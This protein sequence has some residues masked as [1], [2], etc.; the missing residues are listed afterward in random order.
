MSFRIQDNIPALGS[1]EHP[2]CDAYLDGQWILM[3]YDAKNHLIKHQF[4]DWLSPGKHELI[5]VATDDRQNSRSYTYN[6]IR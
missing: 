1:A 3:E 2:R 5:L 6:F 4:E